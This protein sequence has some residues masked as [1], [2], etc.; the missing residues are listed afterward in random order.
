MRTRLRQRQEDFCVKYFECGNATEAAIHAG[1]SLRGVRV[2]ACRM[3]TRTNIQARLAELRQ[4][5]E[6]AAIMSVQERQERLSE[7]ARANLT[8][9]M[10]LGADGSWV[11]LGPETPKTAAIQEIRSRTEYDKDGSKPTVHTSVKLHNPLQAIDLLNKMDRVY[12]EAGAFIGNVDK[13]INYFVIDE[14]TK[15]LIAKAG[16]RT[17]L[18]TNVQEV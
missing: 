3:L 16:E 7:I 6:S 14:E 9:F 11:N 12:V 10:E 5:K 17:E 4:K 1:Y 13:Q 15:A 18:L 2:Q 8:N